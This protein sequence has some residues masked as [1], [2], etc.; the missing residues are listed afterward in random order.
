MP[1]DRIASEIQRSLAEGERF[2]DFAYLFDALVFLRAP[3]YPESN[4]W[5]AN[6]CFASV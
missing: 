4:V 6:C 5:L 2:S 1:S 3:Y